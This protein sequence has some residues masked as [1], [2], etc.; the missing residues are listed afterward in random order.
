MV[1]V[2]SL[3]S[4]TRV[5]LSGL[6]WWSCFVLP[7]PNGSAFLHDKTILG[8][9]SAWLE[10]VQACTWRTKVVAVAQEANNITR[11]EDIIILSHCSVCVII[12]L[13]LIV[14]IIRP[15]KYKVNTIHYTTL[16][17]IDTVVATTF[18]SG[19]Y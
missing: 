2:R 6:R 5:L 17:M 3:L 1:S 4:S 8:L 9:V 19:I 14:I 18:S 10:A 11:Q 12:I 13:C 16:V 7:C 15:F